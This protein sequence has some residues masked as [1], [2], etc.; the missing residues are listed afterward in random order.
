MAIRTP[1]PRLPLE[2]EEYPLYKPPPRVGCSGLTIVT[3]ITLLAFGLLLW[4]VTPPMARAITDV[5]RALLGGDSSQA[6][7]DTDTT[8]TG[9]S[10]LATQTVQPLPT[11]P[12]VGAATPTPKVEYVKLAN[13]GGQGVRLRAEPQPNARNIVTV[14]EGAVFM[15][16]GPDIKNEFGTWRHVELPG[17]GRSGYVLDRYLIPWNSPNP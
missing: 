5:P 16:I 14:G 17:D 11:A 8:V 15:I 4:R 9:T 1:E 10:A 3:V 6:N 2:P 12:I 7:T 13:T